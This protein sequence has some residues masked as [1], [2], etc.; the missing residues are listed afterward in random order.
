M[1]ALHEKLAADTHFLCS[2]DACEVL[3]MNDS[4][5]PWL[6]LV[7]K[8]EVASEWFDLSEGHQSLVLKEVMELAD[9]LKQVTNADKINIAALGN[10]VPQ[11][12]IHVIARFKNDI[13]WP[14]PVWGHGQPVAYDNVVLE[15][16][17]NSLLNNDICV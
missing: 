8:L 17:R 11:L 4:R 10:Q 7:P 6:I 13:A 16:F 1:F 5:F 14:N 12:H 2:Q 15:I 3:I 9:T